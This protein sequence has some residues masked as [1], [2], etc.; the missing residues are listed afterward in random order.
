MQ[1]GLEAAVDLISWFNCDE[2]FCSRLHFRAE[3][4]CTG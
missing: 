4:F 3:S 2:D 1:R